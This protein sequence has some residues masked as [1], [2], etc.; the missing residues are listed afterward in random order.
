MVNFLGSDIEIYLR[1]QAPFLTLSCF[2]LNLSSRSKRV[3]ETAYFDNLSGE[4][5]GLASAV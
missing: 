3:K 1:A 5:G 2:D 4:E